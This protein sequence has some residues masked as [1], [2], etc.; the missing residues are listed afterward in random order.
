MKTLE[1][2]IAEAEARGAQAHAEGI[3]AAPALDPQFMK[4]FIPPG[5]L[6]GNALHVLKAWNRGWHTANAKSEVVI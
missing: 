2:T 5:T 4:R 3:G 1:E 6:I